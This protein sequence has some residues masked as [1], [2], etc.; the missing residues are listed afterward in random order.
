MEVHLV[1]KATAVLVIL[2][3]AILFPYTAFAQDD[4]IVKNNGFESLQNDMPSE[5]HAA[6][7]I[8][9]L[10]VSETE[11]SSGGISG[12]CAH[13]INSTDNDVRLY[14]DVQVKP[15]S[16]Y[17]VTGYIKAEIAQ[18]GKGANISFEDTYAYSQ[19]VYDTQGEWQYV[20]FYVKT[21]AMQK[22]ARLLLRI[23]GYSEMS[24]GQAWFDDIEMVRVKKVPEGY[25]AIKLTKIKTKAESADKGRV[26][27]VPGMLLLSALFTVAC[28]LLKRQINSD[29]THKDTK[30]VFISVILFGLAVRMLL[31]FNIMGY[32]NDIACWQGWSTYAAS[33]GL[34]NLYKMDIFIDYPPGYMYVLYFVGLIINGFGPL[35]S[36]AVWLLVKIPSMITDIIAAWLIFRYAGKKFGLTPALILSGLYF[37][38]PAIIVNSSAWGQIDSVL[39]LFV[40]MMVIKLYERKFVPA[41]LF[42]AIGVL[43]KPQMLLFAPVYLT[44]AFAYFKEVDASEAFR[45]TM[46]GVAAG[47]GAFIL[48]IL[49][50]AVNEEPLWIFKIYFSTLSSYSSLSLNACNIWGLF[51]GMWKPVSD[52]LLGVPYS[53]WGYFGL[54]VAVAVYFVV[55]LLDKRREHIFI[56][57][58][59]LITG[60]FM[61]S[62]K[63]HERYMYPAMILLMMSYLFTKRESSFR[64]FFVF[65]LTQFANTSLVLANQY[66]FSNDFW[67]IIISIAGLAGYGYMISAIYG[68][69]K[70]RDE[71]AVSLSEQSSFQQESDSK[72]AERLKEKYTGNVFD[73]LNRFNAVFMAAATLL[74]S[75]IALINLGNNYGP[76]TFWEVSGRQQEIVLELEEPANIKNIMFFRAQATSGA[77]FNIAV[78]E[79]NEQ[80]QSV[81]HCRIISSSQY[82]TEQEKLDAMNLIR[83]EYAMTD[84]SLVEF[85]SYPDIF[86][87]Y[88]AEADVHAKYIKIS[89]I[90]PMIRMVEM[91]FLDE[92]ANV[93]PFTVLST[94]NIKDT[95]SVYALFDEQ[96]TIPQ[97]QTYMN[98]TYF[99]EIYHAGTAWEHI[100]HL[101]PYETT[102]PPLGKVI[103]SLGIRLFGMTPFGWRIMGTLTGILMV[104]VMYLL[105]KMLLKMSKYAAIATVLMTF[106]FMHFTQTRISTIDSYGVFF[107]MLM[108]LFMGIYYNMN[109]NTMPLRKTIWP[110]LLSGAFFG[111]GAASKWI[112]LYAGAGLAVIF[113]YT[114][115][116]R[117]REYQLCKG[118]GSVSADIAVQVRKNYIRNTVIT[119]ALC[120]LFFILIPA[121]IYCASYIPILKS[122][123][124]KPISYIWENQKNMFNYHSGLDASHPFASPWY[125]WPLLIK[126]MW[127]YWNKALSGTEKMSSIAA[128]GNPAVWLVGTAAIITLI[129]SSF[130]KKRPDKTAIFII[131]AYLSQYLP[132]VLITRSMFIYHYFAAVPFF[133]IAIAYYIKSL[134]ERGKID[135]HHIYAYL[136]LVVLLFIFFYPV[137]S[138]LP[139]SSEYGKLLRWLPS[140]F[141]TY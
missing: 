134:E 3:A 119:L 48:L 70:G 32:P 5:W 109:Y 124:G 140:W 34:F 127:Y 51:G 79:D 17:K 102:H 105:A 85:P 52:T 67:T 76:Q 82:A 61:F 108:Y 128:F 56:H 49:P 94:D 16:I 137:L 66:I 54:C 114:L 112:C 65:T 60:I 129:I 18:R 44:T 77:E 71:K 28:L 113:F 91:G 93:I 39:T 99:D 97:E 104:P 9:S 139:I 138:G 121:V 41:G 107:I 30:A 78:S 122:G 11:I 135:N 81:Y 21:A 26:K 50:F 12:N 69:I 111:L 98:G 19:S 15:L 63:M 68:M 103:I 86:R 6:M 47:L 46:A 110:L 131:I 100:Q 106:D 73:S 89:F 118:D 80:Y 130:L 88:K 45:K 35:S 36:N 126:P 43:I 7:Y 22:N 125:E 64:L 123:G 141:F 120:V 27:F 101:N 117:Y 31:A 57:T 72:A 13:I 95:G 116:K 2:L 42:F 24:S 25:E 58:A 62:G 87:W 53:I 38:S 90:T 1:K 4:N 20:E 136:A 55:S 74:Y 37:F 10:D 83:Q 23:G 92:G 8:D 96:G 40:I 75:V 84:S 115:F 29:K 33:D 14:Q 133:I 132:W 59:L